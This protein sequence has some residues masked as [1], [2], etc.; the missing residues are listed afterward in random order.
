M[1]SKFGRFLILEVEEE[2]FAFFSSDEEK[3]PFSAE[4]FFKAGKNTEFLCE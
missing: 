2:F 4:K 1:N 3:F